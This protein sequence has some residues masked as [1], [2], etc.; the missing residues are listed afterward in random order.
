[1]AASF[2]TR[3]QR[4]EHEL[5]QQTSASDAATR[6]QDGGGSGSSNRFL[7]VTVRPVW[8]ERLL[9]KPVVL[10]VRFCCWQ[11]EQLP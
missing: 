10:V 11:Y 4:A 5:A 7:D 2:Q 6:P 3:A 9:Q 1:M 8:I